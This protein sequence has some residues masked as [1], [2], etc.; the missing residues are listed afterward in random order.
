MQNKANHLIRAIILGTQ[1]V[2]RAFAKALKNE[3]QSEFVDWFVLRPN[4]QCTRPCSFQ[5]T[6]GRNAAASNT[7][8]KESVQK[9]R[10]TGLSLDVWTH[11]VD[12]ASITRQ[13]TRN[14]FKEAK[15]ILNVKDLDENAIKEKFDHL[16]QVND[17]AKGGSF[18]IQSK[19]ESITHSSWHLPFLLESFLFLT[20][21]VQSKRAPGW[22]TETNADQ[23]KRTEKLR[24]SQTS[25]P[26]SWRRP[27][28]LPRV[29]NK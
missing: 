11:S 16:F 4:A 10:I 29:A 5:Q 13:L 3:F 2:S 20:K 25:K 26:N 15:Q 22:R 14:V 18:Y 21:G 9:T 17:K 28:L 1:L 7:E 12:R 8:S 23:Q 24:M 6:V 27:M 19:V